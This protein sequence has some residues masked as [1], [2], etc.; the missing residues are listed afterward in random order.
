MDGDPARDFWILVPVYNEVNGFQQRP[1]GKLGGAVYA[2]LQWANCLF[3]QNPRLRWLLAL[4]P[5]LALV[6]VL[7]RRK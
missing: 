1:N 6:R 2:A 4:F 3:S 7:G 5:S